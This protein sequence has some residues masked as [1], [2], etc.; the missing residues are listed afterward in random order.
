M[1]VFSHPSFPHNWFFPKGWV[2]QRGLNNSRS[3]VSL[4]KKE[5]PMLFIYRYKYYFILLQAL[6]YLS[7]HSILIWE[8]EEKWPKPYYREKLRH[9]EVT[10]TQSHDQVRANPEFRTSC[11]Q[12]STLS[13]KHMGGPKFKCPHNL[14]PQSLA[15]SSMFSV[16]LCS[17]I[18]GK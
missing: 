1:A 14:Q 15:C 7:F 18:W 10:C 9:R 13:S 11:P 4:L 6:L 2:Q 3:W 16:Q 5:N 17:G 8:W 12:P